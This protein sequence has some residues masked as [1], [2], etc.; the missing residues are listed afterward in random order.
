MNRTGDRVPQGFAQCV[1]LDMWK[2]HNVDPHNLHITSTLHTHKLHIFN[3]DM[4]TFH[5]ICSSA[6]RLQC[7]YGRKVSLSLINIYIVK[8][9][10]KGFG[11]FRC[12]VPL[13]IVLLVI[14]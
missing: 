2:L 6:P 7:G 13:F 5:F 9:S 8:F 4:W 10:S 14:Y 1:D 12:G 11:G 3:V